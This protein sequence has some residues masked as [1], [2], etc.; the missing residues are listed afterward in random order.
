MIN[1]QATNLVRVVLQSHPHEVPVVAHAVVERL[2]PRLYGL[3]EVGRG[4]GEREGQ[5]GCTE[6]SQ[7][8][9]V[10]ILGG[11]GGGG[12]GVGV[13]RLASSRQAGK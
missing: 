3:D 5:Q 7:L 1:L 9:C 11:V 8:E 6:V 2:E 4:P 10:A 12:E 13:Q